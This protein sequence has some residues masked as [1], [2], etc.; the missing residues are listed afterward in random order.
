MLRLA[1]TGADLNLV[2]LEYHQSVAK[3]HP[4]L[5]VKCSYLNVLEGMDPFD[6]SGVDRGK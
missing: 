5:V 2:N 3:R 4:N 1:Y 6:I